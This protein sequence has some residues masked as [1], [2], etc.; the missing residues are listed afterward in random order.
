VAQRSHKV[1]Q[2]VVK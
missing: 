1:S 2:K